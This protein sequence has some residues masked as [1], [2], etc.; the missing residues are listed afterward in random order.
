MHCQYRRKTDSQ[1]IGEEETFFCLSR[2]DL[3]GETESEVMAAEDLALQTQTHR[4]YIEY[5]N[6]DEIICGN[7]M[8]TGC[9]R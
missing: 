4:K 9:N 8:P 7:K 5:V 6:K 2:G 3:K 1:L